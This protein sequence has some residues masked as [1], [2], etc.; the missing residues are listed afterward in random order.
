M[1]TLA[2]LLANPP[3]QRW[4]RYQ[5]DWFDIDVQAAQGVHRWIDPVVAA[6][7]EPGTEWVPIAECVGRIAA[8]GQRG[9]RW[10]IVAADTD[11]GRITITTGYWFHAT[12]RDDES[13]LTLV[14]VV[15]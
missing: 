4:L 11:S 14:E 13:G 15:R 1:T 10:R 9:E 6:A 2:E 12:M 7:N 5:G 8:E 3:D